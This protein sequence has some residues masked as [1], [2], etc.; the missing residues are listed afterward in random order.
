LMSDDEL[1]MLRDIDFSLDFAE[2]KAHDEWRGDG[3][4]QDVITGIER[5]LDKGL[6]VSIATTLMNAN[7]HQI[8]NLLKIAQSYG[9]LLRINVYKAVRDKSLRLNY[10]EFWDSIKIILSSGKLVSCSEPIINA[11]LQSGS[12]SSGAPC[13]KQSC[14]IDSQGYIYPCVYWN[15]PT[16]HVSMLPDRQTGKTQDILTECPNTIPRPCLTCDALSICRGG[17]MARRLYGNGLENP[18]EFCFKSGT[19]A[20]PNI[21]C[22]DWDE[23]HSECLIHSGYLCTIIVSGKKS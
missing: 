6:N 14:K 1:R 5:C 15:E 22:V 13:G 11:L 17:C 3:N 23:H 8:P 20:V 7:Y 9:I 19:H 2:K 10:T 18:D 12:S 16:S 21:S 4:F